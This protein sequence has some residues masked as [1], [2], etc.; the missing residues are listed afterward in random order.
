MVRTFP[1]RTRFGHRLVLASAAAGLLVAI[2]DYFWA[3][4]IDHTPGVVLVIVS[5]ALIAGA[6]AVIAFHVAGRRWLRVTLTVLILLGLIGT[7]AAAYFLEA[8]VL[9]ALMAIGLAGWLAGVASPPERPAALRH[10]YQGAA[11]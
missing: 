2:Y 7:G 9:L 3:A 6:A 5:T 4:G 8:Y 10:Q 1:A 11:R